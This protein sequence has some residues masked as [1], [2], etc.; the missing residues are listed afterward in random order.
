MPPNT[1]DTPDQTQPAN[2]IPDVN[3]APV[4]DD[5]VPPTVAPQQESSPAD[6]STSPAQDVPASTE[7]TPAEESAS[8]SPNLAS[9]PPVSEADI[10][11]NNRPTLDTINNAPQQETPAASSLESEI[12]KLPET[13]PLET[14]APAPADAPASTPPSTEAPDNLSSQAVDAAPAP[15]PPAFPENTSAK[16]EKKGFFAKFFKHK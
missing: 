5:T 16:P 9:P 1:N 7:A 14:P 2:Q 3:N 12:D 13:T 8:T 6:T 4:V 10:P 11:A 15:A